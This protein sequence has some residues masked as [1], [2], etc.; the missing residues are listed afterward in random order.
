MNARIELT[1]KTLLTALLGAL[2]VL[3]VACGGGGDGGGGG[4]VIPKP[5]PGSDP[6]RPTIFRLVPNF[7]APGTIVVIEGINFGK[8]MGTSNVTYNGVKL[9]V[10]TDT[11]GKTLWSDTKITVKIPDDAVTGLM[12]VNKLGKQS[13]AG[14]N[15]KFSVG[16]IEPPSGELAITSISPLSGKPGTLLLISGDGFGASRGSSIVRIGAQICDINSRFDSATGDFKEQWS[17]SNIEVIVPPKEVFG[18]LPQ[19]LSVMV[20]VAGVLSNDNHK[21]TV[22]DVEDTTQPAVISSVTPMEAESG[23]TIE[24]RGQ[25][26]GNQIGS[27]FVTFAGSRAQVVSWASTVVHVN[28]PADADSGPIQIH[29]NDTAYPIPNLPPDQVVGLPHPI[30]FEVLVP[31]RITGVSPVNVVFGGKV[32]LYGSHLGTDP[33]ILTVDMAQS[34]G[35]AVIF[36]ADKF[37]G[38][39]P[40]FTWTQ[41]A[42]SFVMPSDIAVSINPSTGNFNAGKVRLI[43]FDSRA[44]DD[45]TITIKNAFDG[46]VSANFTAVP[47]QEPVT[48]SC[49]VPGAAN[50]YKFDWDFGDGKKTSGQSQVST[51]YTQADKTFTPKVRVTHTASGSAALFTGPPIYIGQLGMPLIGRMRVTDVKNPE[52]NLGIQIGS[53]PRSPTANLNKPVSHAG[54]WVT[55]EGFNFGETVNATGIE[56]TR[57]DASEQQY[58]GSIVL[59][60]GSGLQAWSDR[61]ITFRVTASNFSMTG[62]V[63]V[64][65]FDDVLSTN[66]AFLIIEPRI[67]GITPPAPAVSDLITLVVYDNGNNIK[68]F[69]GPLDV[70]DRI[71]RLVIFMPGGQ[72]FVVNPT[73]IA[74]NQIMFDFGNWAPMDNTGNPVP[75][76]PGDYTF[77]VWS[78]VLQEGRTEEIVNSGI[79]GP[80]Q[81]YTFS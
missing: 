45:Q 56:I 10:Q 46:F 3:V 4:G 5:D 74:T 36:P 55:I 62:D 54:D 7:G 69:D 73:N 28:V 48:L 78:G 59:D 60:P 31:A 39:D 61:E 63:R 29:I 34:S 52:P 26:F 81:T 38:S 72:G 25:N 23:Q 13:Y 44:A 33:G 51:T 49:F 53:V 80:G 79:I 20:E 68:G 35:S 71:T 64:R 30:N 40:N 58:F 21:Y 76:N 27:S 65:T 1:R 11:A 9:T 67:D 75:K 18:D 19:V 22:E 2:L 47:V 14:K 8:D 37:N 43:T 66:K 32:T 70:K 50:Q 24:I 42:V 57:K 15:A 12:T 77:Y 41:T 6:T 16:T 17:N